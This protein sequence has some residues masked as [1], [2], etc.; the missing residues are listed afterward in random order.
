[1][2]TIRNLECGYGRDTIFR[3]DNL[4]FDAGKIYFIIGKSGVG[5]STLLETLGLM[6]STIINDN[7]SLQYSLD[8]TVIDYDKLVSKE[9]SSVIR[10]K[11][12]SFSRRRVYTLFKPY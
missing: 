9:E 3:I 8:D 12:F 7:Y 6:N 5:K 11:Y 2:I 10:S 4:N 1:M